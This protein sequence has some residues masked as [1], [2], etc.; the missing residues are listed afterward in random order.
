MECDGAVCP[1]DFVRWECLTAQF[2]Q[3]AKADLRASPLML[4]V[5]Y[6]NTPSCNNV[7]HYLRGAFCE[8]LCI[9]CEQGLR[10]EIREAL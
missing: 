3:D 10:P 2:T 6:V 4:L 7:S 9:L 1:W 5:S 8:V